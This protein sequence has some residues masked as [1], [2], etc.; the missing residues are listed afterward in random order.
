MLKL[1]F[2]ARFLPVAL[3]S[4]GC[5]L[6]VGTPANTV[7]ENVASATA[8][9]DTPGGDETVELLSNVVRTTVLPV[10]APSVVPN[11][12][13]SAPGQTL[14]RLPGESGVFTYTVTNGGNDRFALAL[15]ADVDGASN[16]TPDVQVIVDANGNGKLDDADMPASS[17]TLAADARATVFVKVTAGAAARGNAFVNLAAACGAADGGAR[18]ADNVSLLKV[19]EPPALVLRKTFGSAT[20]RPGEETTV[21]VDVQNTGAGDSREVVVTDALDTPDMADFT[22]VPGS[23]TSTAGAVSFSGDGVT[24]AD[25]E[26][27]PVRQ[28]RWRL[29]TV[30]A[31][32]TASLTFR[33]RVPASAVGA[34]ANT[35]TLATPNTPALTSTA[36]V[37]VRYTPALAIG[38]V[39]NAR[40]LPGGELSA[41]DTQTR[42]SAV[43]RQPVCFVHTLANLGDQDDAVTLRADL[44]AGAADVTFTAEDGGALAQPLPLAR[45]ASVNVRVCLTPTGASAGA[46]ALRVLIT[47]VSSV[48]APSNATIDRVTSVATVAP[49]L[50]KTVNADGTVT[51]GT[52][53]TYTL[54]VH[55]PYAFA[56]EGVRVT[57][58]LSAQLTFVRASDGGAF[59]NGAVTWALG[60]LAPGETRTLTLVT[61]VNADAPDD[62]VVENTFSFVSTQT[63]TPVPSP[64]TRT[65]VYS[66]GLPIT[67][68]S[69]PTVV[70]VGDRITYTITLRN[71]SRSATFRSVEIEDDMPR[72][73]SYLPG[74][75]TLDGRALPDPT[76][77]SAGA[78]IWTV[79]DLQPGQQLVLKFD[80][81]VTPEAGDDLV[82]VVIARALGMNGSRVTSNFARAAN[83]TDPALFVTR[84]DLVGYVFIDRNRDGTYQKGFDQPIQNARVVLANGRVALTDT[85]GRYHFAG[86]QEGFAALRLDPSS[87]PYA[88]LSVPQDG[89]RD[90]SRGV[91]IRN[92]TSVDFPLGA[93]GGDIA[94]LRD[95]TVRVGDLT[96][97]KQVFTTAERGVYL[98]QLTLSSPRDLPDF[99][100]D[101]PLPDGAQLLDGQNA[102]RDATL[103][104]GTHII[105]YRFR[106]AGDANAAVTD[107]NAG[108]RY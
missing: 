25:A 60:A 108:W 66:S 27:T 86:V 97:F 89:A 93:L 96:I 16:F 70:T 68:T 107:P 33:L 31:G 19:G 17:V 88:A 81:R 8:T 23:A 43:L 95:T 41:D 63:P 75:A 42:V 26:P 9:L 35:V 85:E 11:G 50:N 29:P 44:Q 51:A 10:C 105:T 48:G 13:L 20:V 52:E 61:T 6:A 12:T 18:D 40:A 3:L 80:A 14:A 56:L 49:D 21:R 1:N 30:P 59:A 58:P 90:G 102:A 87:V 32:A 36:R 99:F 38:P 4:L 39:G 64:T 53:L 82:N 69:T 47:A 62:V 78:L 74:T 55:N 103:T 84:G 57:D 2:I 72:G 77:K 98:T 76:V 5:A 73:L 54:T 83:K 46:D 91:F 15:T 104:A 94:V 34:R 101:D 92:L 67:K 71:P 106:F 24:F 37:D 65:P 79:A 22:F 28:V 100:L 45:G 7:I